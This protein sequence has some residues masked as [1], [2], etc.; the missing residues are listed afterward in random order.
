MR[1]DLSGQSILVDIQPHLIARSLGYLGKTVDE[2]QDRQHSRA[3]AHGDR[4]VAALDLVE[5]TAADE[6]TLGHRDRRDAVFLACYSN[7]RSEFDEGP[8]GRSGK[9]IGRLCSCETLGGGQGGGE[10]ITG[11]WPEP[12]PMAHRRF[13]TVRVSVPIM[14]VLMVCLI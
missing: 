5:R 9:R 4:R 12:N 11:S 8:P 1:L 2:P 10:P 3:D 6:H 14:I 13:S 7:V